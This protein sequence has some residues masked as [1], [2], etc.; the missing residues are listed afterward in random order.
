[1]KQRHH[2]TIISKGMQEHTNPAGSKEAE[3]WDQPKPASS[4]QTTCPT[5][6]TDRL[7]TIWSLQVYLDLGE[8]RWH[9]SLYLCTVFSN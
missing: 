4:E 6:N 9:H 1:M 2:E 7:W 3:H 8:D 5:S